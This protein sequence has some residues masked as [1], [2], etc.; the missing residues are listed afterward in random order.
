MHR[1]WNG[2]AGVAIVGFLLAISVAP[3]PAEA[4]CAA[5][6]LT[7]GAAVHSDWADDRPGLCR[8][9][10]PGDIPG[11][12]P[13]HSNKANVIRRPRGAWPKV[14]AG[15]TVKLFHQGSTPPRVLRTAPNGDIFVAESYAG[16]IRIL[17][18]RDRCLLDDTS[19]FAS[20]LNRPF[21]IAFYPPGPNPRYVYVAENDRV[22]RY[23]YNNGDR[24]ASKSPQVIARLP[25]GAGRLPGRGHWTRDLT[26]SKDGRTL[27]VSVGSYSNA[28]TGGEDETRRASILAYNP[29]GSNLRIF[30]SGLR[31]PVS[32]A[33][34]PING[35]LWTTVNERDGLGDNV[36]PDFVTSVSSGQFYGWP[37]FYIGSR[38]DP[39]HRSSYPKAHAAISIPKV[40]LQAHSASLGSAFYTGTQFP[41]EYRRSLFVAAHGSWNRKSPTGAK[42]IRLIFDGKGN[43]APYYEDF[44]TGFVTANHDV[45]G[46]P[47]GIAV[48]R[49]GALYVSEDANHAI[50]C[51]STNA[52]S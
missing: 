39:R 45:W 46:R 25:Q 13:S 26:F 22:V 33:I 8:E 52:A 51:V 19:T 36:V 48:G 34:S 37:W 4:A 42:V 50:W 7:G 18:P 29:D 17:R 41:T 49:N 32:L 21:G 44:M 3:A 40:L 2:F 11:V 10:R 9:I 15:F 1:A 12:G 20:G 14:P 30:A 6:R 43:A 28:Q 47:V 16:K 23:P 31:N 5:G 38:I 24:R 35:Q 27:Y